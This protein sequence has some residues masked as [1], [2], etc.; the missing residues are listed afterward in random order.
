MDFQIQGKRLADHAT[1]SV[2]L[3]RRLFIDLGRPGPIKGA[4]FKGLA[5]DLPL[6]FREY[7]GIK[8][9]VSGRLQCNNGLD[10]VLDCY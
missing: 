8:R 1:R 4:P 9:G 10:N 2:C 3:K 7:G 6:L 5:S